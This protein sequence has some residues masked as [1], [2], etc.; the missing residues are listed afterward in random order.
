LNKILGADDANK[1]NLIDIIKLL[2]NRSKTLV[3]MADQAACF[4]LQ[5][6]K[7]RYNHDAITKFFNNNTKNYLSKFLEDLNKLDNNSWT[8]DNI[9]KLVSDL[10]KDFNIKMPELAQPIRVALI[11]DTESPAVNDVIFLM[12]K[13]KVI[14]RITI[15]LQRFC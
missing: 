14:N 2:K 3:E 1:D 6:D 15:A 13:D 5:D 10:L 8:L 11:G 7:I 4:Y 12:G 9:K